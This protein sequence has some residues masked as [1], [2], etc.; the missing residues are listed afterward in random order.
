[1]SDKA[2]ELGVPLMKSLLDMLS[3]DRRP[4]TG[5]LPTKGFLTDLLLDFLAKPDA[6]DIN[7]IKTPPPSSQQNAM[8]EYISEEDNESEAEDEALNNMPTD[9]EL[10]KW[11]DAYV[12]CFS[13]DKAT[14][15]HAIQTASDKFEMN[16][17]KKRPVI[18]NLLREAVLKA[19]KET[20]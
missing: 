18:M 14:A 13:M 15:K 16:L 4:P 19:E 1:M 2:K 11:V 20:E 3:L 6:N 8:T 12:A 7:L 9:A 10:K 5:K 17:I